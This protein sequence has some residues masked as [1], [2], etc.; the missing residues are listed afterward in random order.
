M[1]NK[2]LIRSDKWQNL[3]TQDKM[4]DI[5]KRMS[6]ILSYEERKKWRRIY[7][8]PEQYEDK[9]YI[10]GILLDDGDPHWDLEDKDKLSKFVQFM[11]KYLIAKVFEGTLDESDDNQ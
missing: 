1:D 8:T 7:A 5:F 11:E 2:W 4:N 3:S 6:D 10:N 9:I